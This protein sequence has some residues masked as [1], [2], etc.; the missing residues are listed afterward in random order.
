MPR[1]P[2]EE[3]TTEELQAEIKSRLGAVLGTTEPQAMEPPEPT[4][5]PT[6]LADSRQAAAKAALETT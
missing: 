5:P 2:Y 3:L 1:R 6:S 4:Q